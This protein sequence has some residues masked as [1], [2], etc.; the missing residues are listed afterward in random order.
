MTVRKSVPPGQPLQP[1]P[2]G[3]CGV[4][5]VLRLSALG[6]AYCPSRRVLSTSEHSSPFVQAQMLVLLTRRVYPSCS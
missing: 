1:Q 4:S 3:K 5:P 2:L 6:A